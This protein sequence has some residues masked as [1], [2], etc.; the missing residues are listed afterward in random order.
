M[1]TVTFT[2][3]FTGGKGAVIFKGEGIPDG[4]TINSTDKQLSF[5]ANQSPGIQ[6]VAVA[7][8]IPAG[9][10]NVTGQVTVQATDPEGTI[11]SPATDNTFK[12]TDDGNGGKKY[13]FLGALVYEI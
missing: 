11:L 10:A 4:Q 12:P 13:T 1:T 7:G 3:T 2:A 5:T 8:T 9:D 6:N